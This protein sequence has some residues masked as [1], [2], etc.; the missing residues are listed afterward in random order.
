MELFFARAR[1][2]DQHKKHIRVRQ[3]REKLITKKKSFRINTRSQETNCHRIDF[4][5]V[6]G[7]NKWRIYIEK[8]GRGDSFYFTVIYLKVATMACH[9][10][11][12]M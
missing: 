11:G 12:M 2:D 1:L 9:N 3:M 10:T 8:P 5:F 7:S 6:R 4:S